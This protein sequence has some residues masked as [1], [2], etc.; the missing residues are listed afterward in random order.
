MARLDK[1][2]TLRFLC[3]FD[4]GG[5]SH[6]LLDVHG[7]HAVVGA[8]IDHLQHVILTNK[9]QRYLQAARAP[10]SANGHLARSEGDLMAR[11][12]NAFD[13]GTANLALRSLVEKAKL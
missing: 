1:A 8:L 5:F 4:V 11:N 3:H 9:R 2:C 10:A 12:R 7:I 13:D 6:E